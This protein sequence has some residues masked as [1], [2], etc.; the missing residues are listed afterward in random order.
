MSSNRLKV[1]LIIEQCNPE[2]ASVPLVGYNFYNSI[3]ELADVHLVTHERNRNAL[4]K[5][6]EGFC[7]DYIPESSFIK[8][9]YRLIKKMTSFIRGTNW[10]L[11]HTLFFPVYAAFNREVYNRF[12]GK[13]LESEYDIVHAMTPMIP[14]YPVKIIESCVKTPFILGPVN[15]GVPFPSGFEET[16][17]KE[18]AHFNFL[19]FFS[20]FI[21]GYA[22]TYK[23]A[24]MILSGSTYTLEMLKDLFNPHKLNIEL[25]FENG[26]KK[27]FLNAPVRKKREQIELLFVGRLVPY[28][29]ADM[30]IEAIGRIKQPVKE[31]LHLTIIGDG[32]ERGRLEKQSQD[33]NIR[34]IIHFTGWIEQAEIFSYY[35]KSDLFCFPSIREFGGAVVLEAMAGGTPCIV[36]DHGGIGEYVTQESG[37]RIKP[38]SK[39]HIINEMAEKITLL[40]GNDDLRYK[41][42]Q[43]AYKRG[44]MFEWGKK[45]EA[46]FDI[47]QKA[48]ENSSFFRP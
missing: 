29:G 30:L 22:K 23:N 42:A 6:S 15:G 25:F 19:R 9:Y 47:Y 3:R 12:S 14:R 44:E 38:V 1:L 39:E 24:D 46:V 40:A 45:A 37:F 2:W 33:L 26:I 48:L 17:R 21:P 36:I 32:P 35:K 43:N 34:D 28:K 13:V 5:F 11:L 10:P 41:I 20:R 18:Y 27:E 16:A 4:S 7:I 31:R 8:Y